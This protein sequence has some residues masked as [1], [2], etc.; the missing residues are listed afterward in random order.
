MILFTALGGTIK[1]LVVGEFLIT[2]Y[3]GLGEFLITNDYDPFH[4]ARRD[5]QAPRGRSAAVALPALV[6]LHRRDRRAGV[7][8][9]SSQ[10]SVSN[11]SVVSNQ[12]GRRAVV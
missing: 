1:Y 11:Q 7:S 3:Y 4:R 5:G 2:N 6:R 8:V 9:I 12:A 10:S